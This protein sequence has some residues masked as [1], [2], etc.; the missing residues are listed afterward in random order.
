MKPGTLVLDSM[1]AMTRFTVKAVIMYKAVT[2][3]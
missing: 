3:K 1:K 2:P